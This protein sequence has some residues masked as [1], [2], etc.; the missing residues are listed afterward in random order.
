MFFIPLIEMAVISVSLTPNGMGLREAMLSLFL[1]QYLGFTPEQ[2]GIYVFLNFA[3]ILIR[4][5]GVIPIAVEWLSRPKLTSG[6]K[7]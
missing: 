6:S 2:L 1:L 4:I 5:V 3:G 7:P